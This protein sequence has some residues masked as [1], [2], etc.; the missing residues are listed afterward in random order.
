[1]RGS[2]ASAALLAALAAPA[3]A[4]P[5]ADFYR[6]KQIEFIVATETGTI[7]DTWARI[8]ARHWPK[9]IP[10]NPTLVVKNMPGAGHIRAA[11]YSFNVAPKD[12]TSI[13]T[14]SH[15]I[16]ASFVMGSATITFDVAKF[17]WLGSPDLPGRM[18]V[19][20]PQA[21]V[22]KG[23]D[24]FEHE[25]VVAGAGATA[26]I[27]Q[28]PKLLHGLLGMK[29]KLVE[30]YKGSSEAILAVERGEVEGLCSTIE[31][32]MGARPG[33]VEDG[34]LKVLFNMER[35]PVPELHAPTIYEF[36][37]TDEQR[38]ILGFYGSTVEFGVPMVAPPGVPADRVAALRRAHDAAVKDPA[39]LTE[40]TRL[41]MKSVPV[42]G[43]ELAER[44][45]ELSAMPPD[46]VKKASELLGGNL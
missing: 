24:L 40:L 15:N 25:L 17:Q 30:G 6:G 18:C 29:F 27:S 34:R 23:A 26:A 38:Q 43:E 12:G 1:L 32:I 16:P 44:M 35:K 7:Y 2:L 33:W 3:A 9:H 19:V 4:Q 28:T 39:L 22:Q 42:T 8:M 11:G 36:A 41:K 14:F 37:K 13:I 45:Q 10:G 20:R 46:I 5:V 31:G 21:R